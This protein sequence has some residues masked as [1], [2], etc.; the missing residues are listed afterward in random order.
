MKRKSNFGL[1]K[2]HLVGLSTEGKDV[3]GL[4]I[5][6]TWGANKGVLNNYLWQKIGQRLSEV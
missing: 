2:N 6:E 3:M 1:C 5:L 4:F